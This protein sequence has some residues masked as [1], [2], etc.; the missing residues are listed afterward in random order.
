MVQPPE[1]Q[2]RQAIEIYLHEAYPA[3]FP[4]RVRSQLGIMETWGGPFINSPVFV[5]DAKLPPNRYALRLG[6]TAYPH[7]KLAIERSPDGAAFLFRVD[8]H[9]HHCCPQA[10]APEYAAF[11]QLMFH[12]QHLAERIERQWEQAGLPTFKSFL[13]ADLQRRRANVVN[14]PAG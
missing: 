2:V 9:D 11:Q 1:K 4:A 6:N 14:P 7:M 13:R 5:P 8:T 3:G 12:N 10:D